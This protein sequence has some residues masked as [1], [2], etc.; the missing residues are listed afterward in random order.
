MENNKVNEL[1]GNNKSW[2]TKDHKNISGELLKAD[3]KILLLK[4]W[5][6]TTK[7]GV[8]FEYYGEVVL[9]NIIHRSYKHIKNH[10]R[11]IEWIMITT[12]PLVYRFQK[13]F[14]QHILNSFMESFKGKGNSWK[15]NKNYKINEIIRTFS[16]N[17]FLMGC[18][19][20]ALLFQSSCYNEF[21]PATNYS[22][23]KDYS[24][25]FQ[26]YLMQCVTE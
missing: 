10:H 5:G 3:L 12:L 4:K 8:T 21:T 9:L 13:S 20:E 19:E 7:Q 15:N 14:W 24:W 18:E 16:F 11:A 2:G 25:T 17:L 26:R 1:P 22:L 23:M 6:K